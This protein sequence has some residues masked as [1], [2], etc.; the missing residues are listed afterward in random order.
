MTVSEIGCNCEVQFLRLVGRPAFFVEEG[1]DGGHHC[2]MQGIS[3]F[4]DICI[5]FVSAGILGLGKYFCE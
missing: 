3:N 1:W 4:S 2:V 5:C